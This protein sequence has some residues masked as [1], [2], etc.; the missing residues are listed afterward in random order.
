MI[1]KFIFILITLWVIGLSSQTSYA[2]DDSERYQGY[3]VWEDAVLPSQ[4]GNYEKA[5]KMQKD[6]F[7]EQNFPQRVWIYTTSDFACYWVFEIDKYADVDALYDEFRKIRKNA[8]EKSKEIEGVFEGTHETTKAWTFFWDQELSFKPEMPETSSEEMNFRFWGF[9]HVEKGKMDDMKEVFKG[10]V[11][12]ASTN[13]LSQSWNTYIA[14]IGIETPML[15]WVSPGKDPVEFYSTNS[16]DMEILGD[17]GTN[18]YMKQKDLMQRYEEKI[19]FYRPDL[20]YF[21]ID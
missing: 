5:T 11:D 10:W 12:L 18:Q 2:Q 3:I 16:K 4:V 7:S 1:S 15:F 17:A 20:S 19:G 14:D 8:P 6:L 13:N 21:P 9:C